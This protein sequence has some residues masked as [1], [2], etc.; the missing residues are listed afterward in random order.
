MAYKKIVAFDFVGVIN[1]YK[2]G[3]VAA[4]IIPD[5]PVPGIKEEIQRIRQA[6][7]QVVMTSSRCYHRR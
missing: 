2:S 6:G 5:E 4:D 7:Y 1:S 3:W